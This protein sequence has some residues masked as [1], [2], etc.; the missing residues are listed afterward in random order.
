MLFLIILLPLIGFFSGS[1]F[2]RFLGKGS[3]FITTLNIFLS[4]CFSFFLFQD[5][6]SSGAVLKLNIGSWFFVDTLNIQWSFCKDLSLQHRELQ[7][8]RMFQTLIPRCEPQGR[9]K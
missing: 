8:R 2:G 6:L 1:L 3:C 5:V 7:F 4:F 9:L